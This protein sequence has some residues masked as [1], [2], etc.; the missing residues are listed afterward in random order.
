MTSCKIIIPARGGSKRVPR[1]NIAD[2]VGHTLL[3]LTIKAA[4]ESAVGDVLVST[5]DF[6]IIQ[7]ATDAGAGVLSR[8]P[9]L[10]DDITSATDVVKYHLEGTPRGTIAVMLQPTTPVR[11]PQHIR[12]A[13]RTVQAGSVAVLGVTRAPKLAALVPA[14]RGFVDWDPN[15]LAL[16]RQANTELF[17][18]NGS[19]FAAPLTTLDTWGGFVVPGAY[20]MEMDTIH[21]LE[22]D[23]PSDLELAKAAIAWKNR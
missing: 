7:M 2:F 12:D 14:R 18:I 21:S 23:Y 9:E 6:E 8:P 11:D 16:G 4:I 17:Q 1:K 19:L 10:A 3:A 20:L 5:E 13:V 22:I 15:W